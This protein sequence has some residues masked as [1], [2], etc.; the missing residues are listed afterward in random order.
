MSSKH[1]L[2]G[3]AT[4]S[5]ENTAEHQWRWEEVRRDGPVMGSAVQGAESAPWN[6]ENTGNT[7]GKSMRRGYGLRSP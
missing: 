5:A 2:S 1:S 7:E 6:T 3:G 4:E